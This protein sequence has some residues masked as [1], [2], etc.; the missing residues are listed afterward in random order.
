MI[1]SAEN[2]GHSYGVRTLFKNI[3]FNIEE[4]DKI[5][6]IGVNG[7]GKSTLLRDIATGEPSE[8]KITKNGTCVIEYLPQEIG[9]AHV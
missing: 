6:V 9:R 5:G 7:T 1:L 2:L 8:G 3:S 4:G